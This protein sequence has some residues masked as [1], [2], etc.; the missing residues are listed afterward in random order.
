[1]TSKFYIKY[2]EKTR[3]CVAKVLEHFIKY[4][5]EC[6]G[7]S[8]L[9]KKQIQKTPTFFGFSVIPIRVSLMESK[10]NYLEDLDGKIELSFMSFDVCWILDCRKDTRTD[11]IFKILNFR[12]FSRAPL[13]IPK[14]FK[15]FCKL[16]KER[17]RKS[18]RIIT[19]Y[20]YVLRKIK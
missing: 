15:R 16:I 1:M 4:R 14:S 17:K 8:R 13:E 19:Y 3:E 20:M 5:L 11:A 2:K 6:T 9:R 10:G 12:D 18:K 7:N